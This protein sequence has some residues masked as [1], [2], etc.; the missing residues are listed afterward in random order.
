MTAYQ[1]AEGR[2]KAKAR[3]KLA[4]V[5]EKWSRAIGLGRHPGA[6]ESAPLPEI[7]QRS[8]PTPFRGLSGAYSPA[9]FCPGTIG[10]ASR[11]DCEQIVAPL[12]PCHRPDLRRPPFASAHSDP[13]I[14]HYWGAAPTLAALSPSLKR[15]LRRCPASVTTALHEVILGEA[16]RD[17]PYLPAVPPGD[18]FLFTVVALSPPACRTFTAQKHLFYKS[19]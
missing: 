3:R 10:T 13:P 6:G 5:R 17:R 1:R 12:P 9:P 2:R 18:N 4:R 16:R 15:P 11:R 19:R 7:S 14:A 8:R